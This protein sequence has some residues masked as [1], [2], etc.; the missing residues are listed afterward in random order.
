MGQTNTTT[1]RQYVNKPE[2]EDLKERYKIVSV[3]EDELY[4][5][6]VYV[7][8]SEIENR[9]EPNRKGWE[10]GREIDESNLPVEHIEELSDVKERL[11]ITDSVSSESEVGK[12]KI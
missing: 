7:E 8:D 10:Y 2:Q 4:I 5:S 12:I 1:H 9:Y 11:S 3:E 6:M